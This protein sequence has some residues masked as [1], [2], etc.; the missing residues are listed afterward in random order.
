MVKMKKKKKIT[1]KLCMPS[2]GTSIQTYLCLSLRFFYC[3][4]AY[5]LLILVLIKI[6][7]IDILHFHIVTNYTYIFQ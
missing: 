7:G 6:I 2:I 5:K 3:A 4:N 1:T